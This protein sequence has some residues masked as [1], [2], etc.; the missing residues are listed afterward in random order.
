M[1]VTSGFFLCDTSEVGIADFRMPHPHFNRDAKL[2]TSSTT[3]RGH[4]LAGHTLPL[5]VSPPSFSLIMTFG[6]RSFPMRNT[7]PANRS[8]CSFICRLDALAPSP[9]LRVS[10]G[11]TVIGRGP[12]IVDAKASQQEVTV[13]FPQLSVG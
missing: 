6:R 8:R 11:H 10:V 5:V 2:L 3:R 13:T 9:I 1:H 7:F 4:C 12:H